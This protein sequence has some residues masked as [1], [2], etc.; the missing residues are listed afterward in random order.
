M[1]ERHPHAFQ[2]THQTTLLNNPSPPIR[3][4]PGVAK[5]PKR[6]DECIPDKLVMAAVLSV[7]VN[8]LILGVRRAVEL[9]A[10]TAG[11]ALPCLWC[12]CFGCV[13]VCV[14]ACVCV[15]MCVCVCA[16]V[17][18]CMCVCVCVCVCVCACLCVCVLAS[19]SA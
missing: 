10:V 14:C 15:Y 17:C 7:C 13:C 1:A 8:T 5:K 3:Q 18:V 12:V 6:E 19:L 16:C 9:G 11:I 4:Q 2:P